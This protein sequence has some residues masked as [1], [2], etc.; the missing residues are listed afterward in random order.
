MS[1]YELLVTPLL[2]SVQDVAF[3]GRAVSLL[4]AYVSAGAHLFRFSRRSLRLALQSTARSS[5]IHEIY[6]QP[7]HKK[8][9]R[10]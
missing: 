1:S 5:Y 10:I 8:S 2:I 6:I 4:V 9:E 7:I 3:R